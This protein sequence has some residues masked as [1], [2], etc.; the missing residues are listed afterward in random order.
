M[1]IREL[2]SID[3]SISSDEKKP[4]T[5][6]N[7]LKNLASKKTEIELLMTISNV[8]EVLKQDYEYT[9]ENIGRRLTENV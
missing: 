2:D 7:Y 6:N 4:M 3:L 8:G 5:D 1:G 9:K